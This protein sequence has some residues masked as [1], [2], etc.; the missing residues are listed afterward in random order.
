MMMAGYE[1]TANALAFTLYL[2]TLNRHK[3]ASIIA[4]VLAFG[5]AIPSYADLARYAGVAHG[6]PCACVF[7]ILCSGPVA[8]GRRVW[9]VVYNMTEVSVCAE[10]AVHW[11]GSHTWRP[12]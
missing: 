9:E 10:G 2:L 3:E 1:S 12:R 8:A 6:M 5:S 11:S 4:E 7:S